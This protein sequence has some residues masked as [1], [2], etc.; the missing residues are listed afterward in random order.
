MMQMTPKQ[1][2][3]EAKRLRTENRL[4]QERRAQ[5][6][7]DEEDY[8]E[9]MFEAAT[10]ALCRIADALERLAPPKSPTP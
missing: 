4:R 2:Y 1:K 7:H 3:N 6:Y 9:A 8:A 5:S 10:D